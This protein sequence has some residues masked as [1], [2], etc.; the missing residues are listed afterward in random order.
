M[1]ILSYNTSVKSIQN[2]QIIIKNLEYL[3]EVD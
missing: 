1:L 2:V 3:C